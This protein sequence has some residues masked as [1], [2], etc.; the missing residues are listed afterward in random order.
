MYQAA[1]NNHATTAAAI[2]ASQF[3]AEK[4]MSFPL[5]TQAM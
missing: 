2:T 5:L 3:T 4:S 1:P